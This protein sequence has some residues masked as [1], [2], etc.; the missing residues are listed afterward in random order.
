MQY[1]NLRI[2]NKSP[3][4]NATNENDTSTVEWCSYS[5][6]MSIS[7]ERR[8]SRRIWPRYDGQELWSS[9][10]QWGCWRRSRSNLY[11]VRRAPY[12]DHRAYR[13]RLDLIDVVS[14]LWYTVESNAYLTERQLP[15]RLEWVDNIIPCYWNFVCAMYLLANNTCSC[16]AARDQK[17]QVSFFC[18]FGDKKNVN[19]VDIWP[20]IGHYGTGRTLLGTN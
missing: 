12:L 5:Q 1:N 15:I 3:Q 6:W 4:C 8:F 9:L 19:Y 17:H 10:L 16:F 14:S 18:R 11:S 13:R 2:H 7:K 20:L